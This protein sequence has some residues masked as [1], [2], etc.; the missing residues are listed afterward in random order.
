M[1]YADFS[2]NLSIC[3]GTVLVFGELIGSNGIVF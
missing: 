2:T 1:E 3:S